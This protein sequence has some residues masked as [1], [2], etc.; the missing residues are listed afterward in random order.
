MVV[1]SKSHESRRRESISRKSHRSIY[2]GFTM[3]RWIVTD[4]PPTV[5]SRQLN[6]YDGTCSGN[7]IL[8]TGKACLERAGCASRSTLYNLP[9]RKLRRHINGG[10]NDRFLSIWH[11]S[12]CHRAAVYN[13]L[14]DDEFSLLKPGERAAFTVCRVLK[15]RAPTTLPGGS[16]IFT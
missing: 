4:E 10:T 5:I 9:A 2:G 13:T 6:R 8:A 15:S 3:H 12:S 11:P 7:A 14:N 16:Q 1:G